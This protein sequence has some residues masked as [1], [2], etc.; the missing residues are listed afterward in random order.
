VLDH[1]ER[2]RPQL[3]TLMVDQ[4]HIIEKPEIPVP[5]QEVA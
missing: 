5:Y 2:Y 3:A 1:L 4:F